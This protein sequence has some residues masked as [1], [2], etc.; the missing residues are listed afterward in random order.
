MPINSIVIENFQSFVGPVVIPVRPLTFLF[1]PN[2][3]GKSAVSDALELFQMTFDVGDLSLNP[4]LTVPDETSDFVWN[5]I[6]KWT[7]RGTTTDAASGIRLR[8]AG[9]ASFAEAGRFLTNTDDENEALLALEELYCEVDVSV[10]YCSATALGETG[11]HVTDLTLYIDSQMAIQLVGSRLTL[12]NTG[13][14]GLITRRFVDYPIVHGSDVAQVDIDDVEYSIW[15]GLHTGNTELNRVLMLLLAILHEFNYRP[16][17]FGLQRTLADRSTISA[18]DCID[19]NLNSGGAIS[20]QLRRSSNRYV[21]ELCQ[22]IRQRRAV[23]EQQ[24]H[25]DHSDEKAI[26]SIE[27]NSVISDTVF[28]QA[29]VDTLNSYAR[30]ARED[31]GVAGSLLDAVNHGLLD[32]FADVG[33]QIVY[34][35]HQVRSRVVKSANIQHQ[36]DGA[37]IGDICQL[38]LRDTDGR[39]FDF[40]DVGTGISCVIPVLVDLY[41]PMV[42]FQQPELHL[43]PAMQS[44]LADLFVERIQRGMPRFFIESHSEYMLIRVLRRVRETFTGKSV[45]QN[46]TIRP[47][48]VAVL[49]FQPARDGATTITEIPINEYGDFLSPWPQGFFEERA[50]DLFDE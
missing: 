34:D 39:V 5:G 22:S 29:M 15:R 14:V 42:F 47:D 1:G 49:Y 35:L 44:R 50:R 21:R 7:R 25:M 3:A 28:Q 26:D 13:I 43:H 19:C 2:S 17:V 10:G 48:Q 4:I 8:V 12:W 40:V 41:A 20:K 46:L 27:T 24:S 32:L 6:E 16:Y 36:Q 23:A 33:Y 9:T 11:N 18:D 45:R 30:I 31:A 37:T 38:F